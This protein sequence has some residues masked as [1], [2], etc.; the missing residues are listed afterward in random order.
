[1]FRLIALPLVAAFLAS[2]SWQLLVAGSGA[3]VGRALAG[4]RGR[5]GT[6]LASSAMILGLAVW[7]LASGS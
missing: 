1:M 4:P 3:L 2:A 6:A 5:L 7:T